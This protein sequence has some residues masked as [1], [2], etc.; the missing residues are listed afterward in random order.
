MY[1]MADAMILNINTS[2]SMYS[3]QN[4]LIMYRVSYIRRLH[5]KITNLEDLRVYSCLLLNPNRKRTDMIRFLINNREISQ[6][7]H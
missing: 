1:S 7:S 6:E 5:Q 4:E 3:L 2:L